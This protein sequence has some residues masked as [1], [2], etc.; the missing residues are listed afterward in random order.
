MRR[1]PE[2]R[3]MHHLLA[4]DEVTP[5]MVE[6]LARKLA[7]FHAG[8]ETSPRI[9]RYGD[10]AIRY[11]QREN[12]GQWAPYIG[13]VLSAEQDRILRAYSEAFFAR[14]ADVLKRRVEQL[15]ICRVHADLRSDAVCFT[16]GICVYDCVEFSRRISLLDVARD[17]GFLEMDLRERGRQ[18]LGRAF[19]DAYVEVSK[20]EDLRAILDFYAMYSAS[21]RG[22]V[23]A[24]LLD[25]PEIPE[26]EKR[27]AKSVA[28][29]YFELAVEYAR[30]LPPAMLVMMC[31]LPATGKSSLAK[32]IARRTGFEVISS[33]VVRK[34]M[35]GISPEE[36]RYEEYRGGI[37]S[38]DATALTY[39]ALLDRARPLLLAGQSVILDASF[40]R[41]DQ[42]R[43]AGRLARETG[44]QFACV[45]LAARDAEIRRR[46]ERRVREGTDPS[47]AR[48]E[49]YREQKRRFQRPSEV[50][51]VRRITA[52]VSRTVATQATGVVEA[53]R[54]ISP[55]SLP[56]NGR[57]SRVRRPRAP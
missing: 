10:W 48:W 45:Y 38:A 21:V 8:A 44:A 36:H 29:R 51:G 30:E 47:D 22:K 9:A 46:I 23:K 19:V 39:D 31:G 1:L 37:Y 32:E 7:A 16:N 56:A 17:V 14:K 6:E 28:S 20:D 13:R 26:K 11:N 33:D 34:E 52:E 50:P 27:R 41:R 57:S 12:E 35:A 3:M 24:F 15:R 49:I 4:R 42:R 55:L 54:S 18:D 53:L 25:L 43:A 2:E 40:L 5:E